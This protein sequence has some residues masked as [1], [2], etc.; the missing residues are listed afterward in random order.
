MLAA[1]IDPTAAPLLYHS[2]SWGQFADVLANEARLV[3]VGSEDG[4][5]LDRVFGTDTPSTAEQIV[6]TVQLA[7]NEHPETRRIVLD[8]ASSMADPLLLRLSI[9]AL[10]GVVGKTRV[11]LRAG[12]GSMA[13]ANVL[14]ALK[15]GIHELEVAPAHG[16]EHLPRDEAELM[17]TRMGVAIRS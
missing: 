8:D 7:L 2:R 6:A 10:S 15:S 4:L 14:V 3:T 17:L 11:V 5:V 9:Q 13:S 1:G 16:Q 12:A